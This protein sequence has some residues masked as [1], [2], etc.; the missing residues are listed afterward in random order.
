MVRRFLFYNIVFA[1]RIKII[2]YLT[3]RP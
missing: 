2:T 3:Y 1:K